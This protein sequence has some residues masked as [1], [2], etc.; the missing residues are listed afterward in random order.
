[1]KK[2]IGL[3]FICAIILFTAT[4]SFAHSGRTDSNGGHHTSEC[5]HKNGICYYHHH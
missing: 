3:L 2:R 5:N 1:M 4:A